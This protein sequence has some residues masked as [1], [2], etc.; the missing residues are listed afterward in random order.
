MTE[1]SAQPHTGEPDV[2]AQQSEEP[3]DGAITTAAVASENESEGDVF[4]IPSSLRKRT[5][6]L[7]DEA[8]STEEENEMSVPQL[9]MSMT[10]E[11]DEDVI[12]IVEELCEESERNEASGL[13]ADGVSFVIPQTQG[14][15]GNAL[16]ECQPTSS[17]F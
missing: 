13:T 9:S 15:L 4:D 17:P 7:I 1:V 3:A 16:V 12:S 2:L 10:A 5:A 14:T 11:V 6:R 8:E